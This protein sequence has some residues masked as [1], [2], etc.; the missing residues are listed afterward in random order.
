LKVGV[1]SGPETL[2]AYLLSQKRKK[3]AFEVTLPSVR[4]CTFNFRTGW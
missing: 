3:L 4:V 2:L 1:H